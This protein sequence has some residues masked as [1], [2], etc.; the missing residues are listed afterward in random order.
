MSLGNNNFI[1]KAKAQEIQRTINAVSDMAPKKN[2]KGRRRV[3]TGGI[4]DDGGSRSYVVITSVS[5][6]SSYTGDVLTSPDDSTVVESGVTIKV[7]GAL[8]NAFEVD[9][10]NFADKSDDV[11]YL[12][13]RILG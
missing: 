5:S 12:D 11:Y 6:P 9:Y 13:G 2:R 1:S 7:L 10:S 4:S 8:T 3:R